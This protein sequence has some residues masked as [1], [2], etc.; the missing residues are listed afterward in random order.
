MSY[1]DSRVCGCDFQKLFSPT[2]IYND[3]ESL[4]WFAKDLL[5]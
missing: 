2:K 3:K 4:S 1:L 5:R